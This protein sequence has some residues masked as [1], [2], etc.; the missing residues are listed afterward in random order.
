MT[1]I[2]D[3]RTLLSALA[4]A[5]LLALPGCANMPGFSLT[6]AVRELLTLSSQR[7]FAGLIQPGGF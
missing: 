4:A 5:P 2:T 3:R 6:D 1:A 7:A